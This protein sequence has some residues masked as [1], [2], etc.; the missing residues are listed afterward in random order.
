MLS[1]LSATNANVR[2]LTVEPVLRGLST[3]TAAFS[4]SPGELTQAKTRLQNL[5]SIRLSVVVDSERFSANLE[6][7]RVHR[8]VAKLLGSAV[9]LEIL[10]LDCLTEGA[11]MGYT[12]FQD[13]LGQCQFPKLRSLILS[14]LTSSELELL[15]LLNHSRSLEQITLDPHT[16]IDGSW[17]RVVDWIRT[18]LPLLKHAD[19]HSLSGGF[20]EPWDGIKYVDLYEGIGDFLF[21][22]GVNPFTS[23]ALEDYHAD[24]EGGRQVVNRSRGSGFIEPYV[25]YH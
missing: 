7:H 9:N 6:T 20:D 8:N 18:S 24:I 1:A 10:E 16:L 23:K 22:Q 19:F 12:T 3:D 21:R 5:T 25:N 13:I 4:M 2:E 11:E 17:A 15:R 14:F